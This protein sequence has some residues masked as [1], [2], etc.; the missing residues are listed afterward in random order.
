MVERYRRGKRKQKL[1]GNHQ[2]CWIWGRNVVVETLKAGR[3]PILEL[4]LADRL[5]PDALQAARKLADAA[6]IPVSLESIES[7]TQRCRSKEHQGYLAKM[8]PYSYADPQPI[9][10][11]QNSRPLYCL[12]D[13]IQDPYNFGAIIRSANVM[14]VDAMFVSRHGQAEVT[15]LVA[16]AS[17]GAVSHIPIAEVTD[18]VELAT[19]LRGHDVQVVA[20]T[21]TAERAVFD[22]DFRQPT[23]IVVGNEGS[24]IRE[25]LLRVCD[26]RVAIPQFGEID[27]LNAAVSAGILFYEACRQRAADNLGAANGS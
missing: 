13:S 11:A 10:S 17:A 19:D 7:L 27:S 18:L 26:H 2:K 6:D 1:L 25:E 9:L 12:L 4:C 23:A 14:G 16:R 20:A 22:Y 3:W 5:A 21:Q 15:S 24:G 8:P